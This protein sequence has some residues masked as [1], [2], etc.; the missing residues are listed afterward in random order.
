[1]FCRARHLLPFLVFLGAL[2]Y[3]GAGAHATEGTGVPAPAPS[4]PPAAHVAL[5]LPT[6]SSAFARPAEAVHAGFLDAW[7][8]ERRPLPVRLYPV[9]D[10]PQQLIASYSQALAAGARLVVGPLTRNGV[11]ALAA[12]P[13]LIKVPTLAL[14]VPDRIAGPAPGLY[15]LSLHIEAEA[16]QVAQLALAEG[17][18]KA[19][20]VSDGSPLSRRMRDAFVEA[21]TRGGGNHIAD[22]AYATDGPALERMREAASLG[23]A[24][25]AFYALDAQHARAVRGFMSTITGYGTSQLNPGPHARG[26]GAD[27]PDV[28]FVD[29]PWM[30]QPDHP[31]VMI[32]ARPGTR[33]ADDL[34]RLYALGIDASRIA[35]ALLAGAREIDIDGVTG[36]LSLGA[37]GRFRRG[38][39]VTL[40]DGGN[41]TVLGETPP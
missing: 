3:G 15:V 20:T 16:R 25:M 13:Q 8:R 36:R 10:D 41:L 17:R 27:L 24:D 32:Y 37:D 9:T 39:L 5:L 22:Y 2:L 38:L 33:E 14:N 7:K 26:A 12:A 6:G 19:F 18:R 23:V 11:N 31:A 35:G 34:E 29:M 40:I 1:V 30:V 21:F 4:A 28:R